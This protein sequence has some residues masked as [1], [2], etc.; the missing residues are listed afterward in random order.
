MVFVG[1][2]LFISIIDLTVIIAIGII[3]IL[4]RYLSIL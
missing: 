3:P 2:D 1:V 4:G